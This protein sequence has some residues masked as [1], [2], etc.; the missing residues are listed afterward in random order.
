MKKG[1]RILAAL[2]AALLTFSG[3]GAEGTTANTDMESQ[4]GKKTQN[5]DEMFPVAERQETNRL[6]P[7][8]YD[9]LE[10]LQPENAEYTKLAG[11]HQFLHHLR[12][13]LCRLA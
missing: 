13:K 7:A 12:R 5:S 8:N 3:C 1:M 9:G 2:A 10:V 6:R 4:D 11:I